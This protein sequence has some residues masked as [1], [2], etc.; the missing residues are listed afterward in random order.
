MLDAHCHIDMYPDPESVLLECERLGII[1][2]SMTN[3]PSHF[4]VG[5]RH[6]INQ[7]KAR[8]ALGFHPLLSDKYESEFDKFASYVNETS[9]IGEIGLDFS[10][11]GIGSKEIQLKYFYKIIELI[12]TQKKIISLHSRKAEK[13]VLQILV[14]YKIQNA[15]FHWYTGSIKTLGL[16]VDHGYYFS[17]NN[18]MILTNN[19]I[20]II[21]SI[22][23]ER[24][25]TETDGPYI[26]INNRLIKPWDV[27]EVYK[28][29]ANSWGWSMD[30]VIKLVKDNFSKLLLDIR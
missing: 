11:E 26:K 13:E 12:S 27:V 1:T 10:N 17:V 15:I 3:L 19:G 2:I 4:E 16:I 30:E 23:K 24:I 7:K 29:L 21:K 20:K 8:L 18:S 28:Y 9:Y 22:P 14:E 5:Y 6:F 25:L